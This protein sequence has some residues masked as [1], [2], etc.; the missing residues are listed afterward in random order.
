MA[1]DIDLV[2]KLTDRN[3]CSI[4]GQPQADLLMLSF[5]VKQFSYFAF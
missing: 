4:P 3:L 2:I 5:T 1:I